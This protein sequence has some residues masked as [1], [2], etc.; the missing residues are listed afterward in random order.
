MSS[1][2]ADGARPQP[3][4]TEA[5]RILAENQRRAREI[6]EDFYSPTK[7]TNLFW[8]QQRAR[9]TLAALQREGL[10]PFGEKAI[11]EIGCGAGGWLRDLES[12]GANRSRLAGIDL[13]ATRVTSARR[14]FG[15]PDYL[16]PDLPA[17]PDIRAGDA[18][19][20]PWPPEA[21]DIVVQSTVFTSILDATVRQAVARE[22]LRVLRP[23][24]VVLWYDLRFDNPANPNVRGVTRKE[25]RLLFPGCSVRLSRVTLAPPLARRIVPASWMLALALEKLRLLNS[26][27]LGVIRKAATSA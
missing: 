14:L 23:G 19:H 27:Y 21:F 2:P 11:L 3:L 18:S 4:S 15:L 16:V 1:E 17:A 6:P 25:I 12:W 7:V 10:L 24:G 20:L 9:T 22:M 13:D 5:R 26:H 8:L